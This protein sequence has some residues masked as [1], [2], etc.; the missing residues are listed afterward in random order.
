MGLFRSLWKAGKRIVGKVGD[1]AKRVIG[2][3]FN[4]VRKGLH[5]SQ[6]FVKNIKNFAKK[7]RNAPVIGKVL[8]E[9]VHDIPVLSNIND[10]FNRGSDKLETI[11]NYVD[12][13]HDK[14]NHITGA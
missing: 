11:T 10:A 14:F 1:K 13:A 2:N 7:V 5:K 6:N 12:S 4:F 8:N 3:G 9:A